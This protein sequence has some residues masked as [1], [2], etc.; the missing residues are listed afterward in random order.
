MLEALAGPP[1]VISLGGGALGSQRA[2]RGAGRARRRARRGRS[3]HRLDAGLGPRAPARPDRAAFDALHAERLPVYRAAADRDAPAPPRRRRCARR[4]RACVRWP[5]AA[6]RAC[7]SCG[8][9]ARPATTRSGSATALRRGLRGRCGEESRRIVVSDDNVADLYA[10]HVPGLSALIEFPAGEDA[11]VA[12]RLPS[13][14]GARSSSSRRRAP[15]ISSRSAAASSGT[16]RASCAATF[17]RGIPVVQVPTTLVAQVDSAYGGKTGVD[18]PRGQ[19]LRR[20][21]PPAGG[22]DHR[23]RRARDAARSRSSRPVYAEVVKTALI[24]GGDAVGARRRR[25]SGRRRRDPRV[26]AHEARGRR[27][28]RA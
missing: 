18:L 10:G 12:C 15:T 14:S 13:A 19:E 20:R 1:A 7:A 27:R 26:R 8:P 11:Q 22:R 21:L 24:A 6:P 4:C 2:A 28:R 17:Q 16:S 3:R 9:R 5:A 25:G 23:S